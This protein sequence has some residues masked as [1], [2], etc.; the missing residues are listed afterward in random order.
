M[1]IT[2]A[3]SIVLEVVVFSTDLFF[4][5]GLGCQRVSKKIGLVLLG[6]D[7]CLNSTSY[8]EK[9]N[10]TQAGKTVVVHSL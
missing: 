4:G 3:G 6:A 8:K 1:G 2:R 10:A 9:K 7:I 5:G